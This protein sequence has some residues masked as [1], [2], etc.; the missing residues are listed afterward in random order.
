[1]L[2][3]SLFN[4]LNNYVAINEHLVGDYVDLGIDKNRIS[5]IPNGVDTSIF[6]PPD[7]YEKV[8]LKTCFDIPLN[9]KVIIFS[10]RLV[11]EKG[12]DTLLDAYR[13]V[14][15]VYKNV[16]LVVVGGVNPDPSR[17]SRGAIIKDF[18]A[19]AW[20]FD[21]EDAEN[22]AKSRGVTDVKFTWSVQNVAD[23]L[24]C[25]DIYVFPSTYK[26]GLSNSLLEGMSVGLAVVS[27][28]V[29]SV[30]TVITDKETG[31]LFEPGNTTE[32]AS[33]LTY[34]L[35]SPAMAKKLGLN[36]RTRVLAEYNIEKTVEKY[37]EVFTV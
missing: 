36:A 8:R 23:Y 13:K 33:G 30:R 7:E 21:K 12:I 1:M 11:K 29:S 19:K 15:E 31:L 22:I 16:C 28:N 24:K 10:G 9:F 25:A 14:K 26:E 37:V 35:K 2:K 20:A 6:C 5:Y 32:L 27:S 3:K 34:L 17:L 18:D 4:K